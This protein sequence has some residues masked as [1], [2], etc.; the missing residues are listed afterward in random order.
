MKYDSILE[1][2]TITLYKA[3]PLTHSY[4]RFLAFM[5]NLSSR[6]VKFHVPFFFFFFKES[7]VVHLTF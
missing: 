2:P 6:I 1:H 4:Y 7:A 5:F 3:L